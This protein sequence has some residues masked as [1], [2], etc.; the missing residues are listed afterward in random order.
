MIRPWQSGGVIMCLA[1][2]D[3]QEWC[4]P[5]Q[6]FKWGPEAEERYHFMFMGWIIHSERRVCCLR[7]TC[8]LELFWLKVSLWTS[9]VGGGDVRTHLGRGWTPAEPE[10][11]APPSGGRP[12]GAGWSPRWCRRCSH[13]AGRR[14]RRRTGV[15]CEEKKE[16]KTWV[17]WSHTALICK[18]RKGALSALNDSGGVWG[19]EEAAVRGEIR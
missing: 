5:N 11:G 6:T 14:W 2:S 1:G 18:F 9:P 10:W 13:R 17:V 7:L 19:G 4:V 8:L 15:H 12:A 16:K 3:F